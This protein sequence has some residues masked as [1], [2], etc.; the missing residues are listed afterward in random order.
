[1]QKSTTHF[2]ILRIVKLSIKGGVWI[3]FE[4]K[5]KVLLVFPILNFKNG[6]TFKNKGGV[7]INFE[8]KVL[9]VFPILNFKN[10]ET[11]KNK[12]GVWINFEIK[13]LLVFPSAS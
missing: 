8:F 6:E 3:N 11:F 2:Q 10:C 12:K 13:V 4:V 7:W 1:L 9:L 5:V